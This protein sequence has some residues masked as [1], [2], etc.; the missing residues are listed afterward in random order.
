M[1]RCKQIHICTKR[2]LFNYSSAVTFA[3]PLVNAL[4][5]KRHLA[6][7]SSIPSTH[8]LWFT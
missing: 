7:I 8:C 5:K 6:F 4:F 3:Q 2:S 1:H